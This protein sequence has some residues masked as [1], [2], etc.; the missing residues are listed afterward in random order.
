MLCGNNSR[1][2][3]HQILI[4]E[5]K[6]PWALRSRRPPE[7]AGKSYL[8]LIKLIFPSSY[9]RRFHFPRLS[10][11]SYLYLLL[12]PFRSHI[13][14]ILPTADINRLILKSLKYSVTPEAK[15]FAKRLVTRILGIKFKMHRF[16]K[17]TFKQTVPAP[18]CC[19]TGVIS[20][21]NKGFASGLIIVVLSV[22]N[23][24]RNLLS[25]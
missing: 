7:T 5:R 17:Y 11:L 20:C 23:L 21:V 1:N 15:P 16:K 6:V 13:K 19:K 14:I 4:T 25:L 3:R 2:R 22:Q 8:I 10:S 24:E 9:H 18:A 12:S